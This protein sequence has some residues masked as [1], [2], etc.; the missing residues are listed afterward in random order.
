MSDERVIDIKTRKPPVVSADVMATAVQLVGMVDARE[1]IA[2]LAILIHD[3]PD[4]PLLYGAPDTPDVREEVYE[5]FNNAVADL[6]RLTDS[7][8]VRDPIDY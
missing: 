4:I 2:L 8:K 3:C 1:M 5:I 7:F 6:D